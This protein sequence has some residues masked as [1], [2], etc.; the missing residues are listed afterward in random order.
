MRI[1]TVPT[2]TAFFLYIVYKD[3]NAQFKVRIDGQ[4]AMPKVSNN[5]GKMAVMEVGIT[6]MQTYVEL[7]GKGKIYAVV[8]S[9]WRNVVNDQFLQSLKEDD[10]TE[11]SDGSMLIKLS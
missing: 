4:E 2:P 7:I 6:N 11:I 5:D 9:W 8:F 10:I 3:E 1:I